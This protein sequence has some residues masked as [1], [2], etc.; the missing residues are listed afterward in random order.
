MALEKRYNFSMEE[1]DV[2]ANGYEHFRSFLNNDEGIVLYILK[3]DFSNVI[4]VSV[5]HTFPFSF[6]IDFLADCGRQ[7]DK[8][9]PCFKGEQIDISEI[10]Q[11]VKEYER[12]KDVELWRITYCLRQQT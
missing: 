1:L 2:V 12:G 3:F 7:N 11:Y 9:P 4:V 5:S 8:L 6:P 10:P